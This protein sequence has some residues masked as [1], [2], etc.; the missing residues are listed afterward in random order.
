MAGGTGKTA[1]AELL[2]KEVG[3]PVAVLERGYKAKKRRREPFFVSS[4]DEGDEAYMLAQKIKQARVI[5]CR[6]R[7]LGAALAETLPVDYILLDDG[8]Q[9]RYLH[10]DIE[11]VIVHASDL[12]GKGAFLPKGT[13]RDSPKRLAKADYIVINGVR[14]QKSFKEAESQLRIF[15]NAPCVGVSYQVQ[16]PEKWRGKKIAAFCGIGKPDEFYALLK[17]LG[18]ELLLTKSYPDHSYFPGVAQFIKKA[19]DLGAERIVCTEKDFAKINGIQGIVCLPVKLFVTFGLDC[20][21]DLK[22]KL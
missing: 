3:K 7:R 16:H 5:I 14:T 21:K 17:S 2:A 9:H 6:K 1:F 11:I 22:N 13:L 12:F 20:F 8:M 15:S 10:R 4:P 18:C 19:S